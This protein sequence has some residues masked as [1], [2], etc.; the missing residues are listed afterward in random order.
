MLNS[1]LASPFLELFC[2]NY[3]HAAAEW[4]ITACCGLYITDTKGAAPMPGTMMRSRFTAYIKHNADYLI[5]TWHPTAM[6]TNGVL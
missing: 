2:P 5:A 4:S 1:L 3:A 6:P